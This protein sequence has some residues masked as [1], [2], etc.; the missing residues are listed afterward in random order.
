A[1][2]V[3]VSATADDLD[4]TVVRRLHNPHA[5]S[6][7]VHL[8]SNGRYSVMLTGAGSGWSRWGEQAVT[9][10]R[11]DTTCDDWGSY[12]LL[13]DVGSGDVWSAGWQPCGTR[14]DGYDVMFA[15]DR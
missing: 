10:W 3:G 1:E 9:R 5:A 8:L 13:R 4:P 12:V 14:P 6:P 11:E 7:S 15:E 2:E